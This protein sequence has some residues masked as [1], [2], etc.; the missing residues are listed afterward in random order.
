MGR[1][2]K[3]RINIIY[4]IGFQCVYL[5]LQLITRTVMLKHAGLTALSLNGLLIEIVAMLSIAEMGIGVAVS[6][7]LYL[8]LAEHNTKR[9][10]S[11]MH[12]FQMAY[13]AAG[14]A[15]FIL[16]L[17]FMPFLPR[18]I[19]DMTVDNGLLYTSYILFLLI[20]VL[21][22]LF[23]SKAA[24]LNAD[25][26]NYIVSKTNTGFRAISFLIEIAILYYTGNFIYYLLI[27][28]AY[29]VLFNYYIAVIVDR[30]YP[31]LK[32]HEGM[33]REELYPILRDI[34]QMFV[35]KVSGKILNST[36]NIL[37]STLV[38]T[39]MV[40]I[41]S[42]Y[43]MFVNGFLRLFASLNE[44]IAGSV[45]NLMA[46]ETK[47]KC[48]ESFVNIMYFFFAA[49]M[50]T[51][52]CFYAGIEPFLE[53]I[54]G[55]QYT[56]E[57]TALILVTIDLFI[58]IMKMPL[59]LFFNANG[60]FGADQFIS[61]AGSVINLALSIILG[62]MMGM[63][64]IFIGTMASII[65]MTLSKLQMIY[66]KVF[67]IHVVSGIMN[68]FVYAGLMAAGM[69]FTHRFCAYSET[70]SWHPVLHFLLNC[71]VAGLISCV[72]AVLPYIKSNRLR[73]WVRHARRI[74]S[75]VRMRVLH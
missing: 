72:L 1:S 12:V 27:E 15:I 5:I 43:S 16:G 44:N 31:Y 45:G 9:V 48:E 51:A 39:G 56:L 42:Q 64:G 22:Y 24:L 36:D 70:A 71:I 19:K 62:K 47:E 13:V 23:S 46:I 35:G 49:G 8:P 28:L 69:L 58:D 57:Q 29:N 54:V 37:I 20:T 50:I 73:Y 38:S 26:K 66:R 33:Q 34:R 17:I 30:M 10:A 74:F 18:F 21:P 53:G 65:I 4:G 67:Q 32:Q 75:A 3:S 25:Q 2:E 68:V 14:A 60:M 52:C 59:W 40:G 11:V 7:H 63:T 55:K 41:Y 61:I 6:Y